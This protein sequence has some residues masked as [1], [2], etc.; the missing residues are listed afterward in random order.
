MSERAA[1]ERVRELEAKVAELQQLLEEQEQQI[2]Q[3]TAAARE[4]CG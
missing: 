4:A 2:E 1:A 3:L